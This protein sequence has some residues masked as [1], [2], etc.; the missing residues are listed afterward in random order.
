MAEYA[1]LPRATPDFLAGLEANNNRDWFEAHRD[2]YERDW[3]QAG[4]D[5]VEALGSVAAGAV[6]RLEAVPRIGGAL[7]RIQRDTRFSADRSPY[8]PV[9]HIVL[10]VAGAPRHLGMHFVLHPRHLG[11]GAGHYGLDP[12]ALLRFRERVQDQADREA[13]LAAAARIETAAGG[14]WAM[15]ELKRPPRG[16]KAAPEWEHLMRRKSVILRGETMG[17]PDWLFTPACV[18]E[19]RHLTEAHLPLLAWL[20]A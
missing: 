19:I 10:P 7:R 9:L 2:A 3:K 8:A 18:G 20:A 4:L 12:A 15:P 13:L 14:T 11:F 17:L 5:L 16:Y 6:P 1:G